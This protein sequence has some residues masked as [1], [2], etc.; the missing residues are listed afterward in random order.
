MFLLILPLKHEES[1][2]RVPYQRIS[3]KE[4]VLGS[5]VWN[6]YDSVTNT[7]IRTTGLIIIELL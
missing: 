6:I 1:Q 2:N 5:K 7:T 4:N 3:K